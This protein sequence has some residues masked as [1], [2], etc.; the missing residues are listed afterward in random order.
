MKKWG[1][2][3]GEAA[4]I[5]WAGLRRQWSEAHTLFREVSEAYSRGLPAG[6]AEADDGKGLLTMMTF[7][8]MVARQQLSE[9]AT[10]QQE[11]Q[12]QEMGGTLRAGVK[13][14]FRSLFRQKGRGGQGEG[15]RKVES[16]VLEWVASRLGP[17]QL[18]RHPPAVDVGHEGG[19]LRV[20]HVAQRAV[21]DGEAILPKGDGVLLRLGGRRRGGGRLAAQR[22]AGAAERA[23]SARLVRLPFLDAFSAKFVASSLHEIRRVEHLLAAARA[24]EERG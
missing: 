22:A 4:A 20:L 13:R 18:G 21:V 24:K 12:L 11:E 14:L 7:V 1:E 17:E 15:Q 3:L 8:L 19:A 9:G 16:E 6:A 10:D 2:E 5:D 23:G